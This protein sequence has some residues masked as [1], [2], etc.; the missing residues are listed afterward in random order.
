MALTTY[1]ADKYIE[2]KRS[3]REAGSKSDPLS[4]RVVRAGEAGAVQI[5]AGACSETLQPGSA[6]RPRGAFADTGPARV[7]R[8]KDQIAIVARGGICQPGQSA[9][10]ENVV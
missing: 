6:F 7:D 1:W 10:G 3:G 5:D 8:H 2:N 4:G 9:P